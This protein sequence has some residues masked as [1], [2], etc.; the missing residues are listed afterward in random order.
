VRALEEVDTLIVVPN[1]RLLTV[2]DK[3]TSR[4]EAFRVADDVLRQGMGDAA[5]LRRFGPPRG[6]GLAGRGRICPLDASRVRLCPTNCRLREPWMTSVRAK[7][8]LAKPLLALLANTGSGRIIDIECPK[9]H[10]ACISIRRPQKKGAIQRRR[11]NDGSATSAVSAQG[12][13][14][15]PYTSILSILLR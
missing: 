4:V 2:L 1:N 5:R 6:A 13:C 9:G 15:P 11:Y 3:Q 10:T 14:S 8:G 7:S 12:R